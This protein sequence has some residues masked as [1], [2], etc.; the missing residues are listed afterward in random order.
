MDVMI[1]LET[2][3]T[4]SNTMI[5][6]IAAVVFDPLTGK[7]GDKFYE[8]IDIDSYKKYKGEFTF[9]A[10]TLLWWMT[11]APESARKEAFTNNNRKDIAIVMENFKLWCENIKRPIKIWSH[12]SSFDV[13]IVSYTMNILNLQIPWKFWDIRDTRTIYD[14]AEISLK[15]VPK[16]SEYPAHHA[17]G[18]CF[19]QIEALR[20]SHVIL[21]SNKKRR[22]I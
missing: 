6:T 2:L 17:L 7:T 10:S 19:Q 21:S 9:D 4:S 16:C 8:K 11:V 20:L 5:L 18:D 22:I 12:G 1:D 14:L 15:N 3:G 13:V